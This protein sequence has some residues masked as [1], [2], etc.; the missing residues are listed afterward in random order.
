MI[1]TALTTTT[2]MACWNLFFYYRRLLIQSLLSGSLPRGHV[3][4]AG[5]AAPRPAVWHQVRAKGL[6][7]LPVLGRARRLGPGRAQIDAAR[8]VPRPQ[9]ER[10]PTGAQAL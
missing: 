5:P 8:A 4:E 6:S 9:R 10:G 3:P 2:I 7:L 1:S